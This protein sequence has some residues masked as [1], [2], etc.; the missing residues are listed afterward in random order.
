MFNGPLSYAARP[1]K[2]T[3]RAFEN[4]IR[5]CALG[6]PLYH[7]LKWCFLNNKKCTHLKCVCVPIRI[8]GRRF[9]VCMFAVRVFLWF[10]LNSHL[11]EPRDCCSHRPKDEVLGYAT[12]HSICARDEGDYGEK[13]HH[14][15]SRV[16]WKYCRPYA[17]RPAFVCDRAVPNVV[18]QVL[19]GMCSDKKCARNT[20]VR[21]LQSTELGG[22]ECV[23]CEG[24][25]LGF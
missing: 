21:A 2:Y 10:T 23:R 19:R 4:R 15:R 6:N 8:Y 13:D 17:W 24:P 16:V 20:R 3:F 14:H 18:G 12:P 22:S 11:L 1:V 9:S 25:H 5:A 7:I